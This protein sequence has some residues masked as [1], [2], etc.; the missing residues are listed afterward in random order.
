MSTNAPP[1]RG[2]L[3][4]REPDDGRSIAALFRVV[5]LAGTTRNLPRG[6]RERVPTSASD[7][8]AM[9][10]EAAHSP[11]LGLASQRA[12]RALSMRSLATWSSPAMA[13]TYVDTS[14]ETLWPRRRA[15]TPSGT[16]ACNHVVAAA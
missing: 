12:D 1:S 10:N 2:L 5:D 15:T 8:A 16:P 4:S 14:V 3:A 9:P 7:T 13:P 6:A 11:F